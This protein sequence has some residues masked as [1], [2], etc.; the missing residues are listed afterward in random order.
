MTCRL[1]G[2]EHSSTRNMSSVPNFS[3]SD[4][5]P[6]V[7]K[8]SNE[9]AI[10]KFENFIE[11]RERGKLKVKISCRPIDR[12]EMYFILVGHGV[13]TGIFLLMLEYYCQMVK[14]ILDTS[15]DDNFGKLV[16]HFSLE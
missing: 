2:G 10:S 13:M 9:V 15:K 3:A 4:P 12:N 5:R 14:R 16:V 8:D 6:R 1:R 11:G 7:E